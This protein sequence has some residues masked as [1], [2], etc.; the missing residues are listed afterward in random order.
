ME[1]ENF[2]QSSAG[3]SSNKEKQGKAQWVLAH[4]TSWCLG[5]E[6]GSS[7]DRSSVLSECLHIPSYSSAITP[8][9]IKCPQDTL[10]REAP[11]MK[12]C[13]GSQH[14]CEFCT[15]RG[16]WSPCGPL[17]LIAL[18]VKLD[19]LTLAE[20]GE[21]CGEWEGGRILLAPKQ[22]SINITGCKWPTWMSG[23]MTHWGINLR[24]RM[25]QCTRMTSYNNCKHQ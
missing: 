18:R 10:P 1:L 22:I 6:Q 17:N 11:H 7:Q 12:V 4:H 21:G 23:W 25:Q 20:L 5:T 8:R 16:P 13:P 2:L 3:P 15:H 19:L 24:G 9:A 14:Q